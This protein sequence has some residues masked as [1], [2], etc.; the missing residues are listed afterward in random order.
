M[1][2]IIFQLCGTAVQFLVSTLSGHSFRISEL[3]VLPWLAFTIWALFYL[4]YPVAAAG[5][6]LGMALVGLR[7]VKPDGSRVT[8]R[9]AFIRLLTLP[10]SFIIVCYGFIMILV[11]ADHRALHDRLGGTAVIYGWDV[12]GRTDQVSRGAGQ[13][14]SDGRSEL[15]SR[16]ARL[17]TIA[18]WVDLASTTTASSPPGFSSRC[19]VHGGTYT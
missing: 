1:I 3:P 11:N 10:L 4:I 15:Q 16:P 13:R 18:S 17:T 5:R 14:L 12:E 6:T 19:G 9:E 2:V 8:S 7:V